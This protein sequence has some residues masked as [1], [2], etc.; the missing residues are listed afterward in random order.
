MTSTTRRG[1][2]SAPRVSHNNDLDVSPIQSAASSCAHRQ[3]DESDIRHPGKDPLIL[4]AMEVRSGYVEVETRLRPDQ[5]RH[6]VQDPI[7]ETQSGCWRQC[8]SPLTVGDHHQHD[9][10]GGQCESSGLEHSELH[11]NDAVSRRAWVSCLHPQSG[12]VNSS[13][14]RSLC[15]LL[16]DLAARCQQRRTPTLEHE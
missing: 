1:N 9:P 5:W 7:A 13:K 16:S 8:V 10:H 6:E 12:Q 15:D 4:N 11:A 2:R 3:S 14:K